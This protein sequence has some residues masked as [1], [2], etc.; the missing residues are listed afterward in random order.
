[1]ERGE[2]GRGLFSGH[3]GQYAAVS[4]VGPFSGHTAKAGAQY[5]R[6]AV[7]RLQCK[8]GAGI[9]DTIRAQYRAQYGLPAPGQSLASQSPHPGVLG[10]GG[11]AGF[12]QRTE[13]LC[14]GSQALCRHLM[15]F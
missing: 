5:S 1:M 7:A 4:T 11:L 8:F 13:A 10:T 6:G 3:C 15:S 14:P 2:K 9:G 12:V